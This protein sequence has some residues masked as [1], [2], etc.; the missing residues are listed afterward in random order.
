MQ[1]C[2]A[3]NYIGVIPFAPCQPMADSVGYHFSMEEMWNYLIQANLTWVGPTHRMICFLP[4]SYMLF[5]ST[6][7]WYEMSLLSP[8]YSFLLSYFYKQVSRPRYDAWNL[9]Y[10]IAD[11]KIAYEMKSN[12]KLQTFVKCKTSIALLNNTHAL[13]HEIAWRM[14]LHHHIKLTCHWQ[15]VIKLSRF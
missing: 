8:S 13:K 3:S 6:I 1:L 15:K 11:A 4:P 14:E 12:A 9:S 7:W 5:L 10:A 2:S